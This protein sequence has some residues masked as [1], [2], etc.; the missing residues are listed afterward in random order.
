MKV[1]N[2][3]VAMSALYVE[4]YISFETRLVGA[5]IWASWWIKTCA[6]NFHTRYMESSSALFLYLPLS[7][8][9]CLSVSLSLSLSLSLLSITLALSPPPS[10]YFFLSCQSTGFSSSWRDFSCTT[11]WSTQNTSATCAA[12]QKHR[13]SRFDRKMWD[14]VRS[15]S[16]RD[17]LWPDRVQQWETN[18]SCQGSCARKRRALAV[19][20]ALIVCVCVC[21]CPHKN[22]FITPQI[23]IKVVSVER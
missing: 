18:Y 4:K 3:F 21:V 16:A 1:R 8:S 13:Y 22:F 2:L 23:G 6:C 14:F 19:H 10:V 9:V 11:S 7:V 12:H 15:P 20:G 17:C 5:T